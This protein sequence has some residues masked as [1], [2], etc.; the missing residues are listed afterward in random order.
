MPGSMISRSPAV[1]THGQDTLCEAS[2]LG[3]TARPGQAASATPFD[4]D[5][6]QVYLHSS[7][8]LTNSVNARHF[9]R[10]SPRPSRCLQRVGGTL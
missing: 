7:Y 9:P 6:Q 3:D 4:P 10:P 1:C 2:V 5:W 8:F